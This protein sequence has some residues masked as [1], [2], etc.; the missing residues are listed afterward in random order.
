[1]CVICRN[2]TEY[3]EGVMW[4]HFSSEENIITDTLVQQFTSKIITH[5]NSHK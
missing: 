2:G 5:G 4:G 3:N 1:M